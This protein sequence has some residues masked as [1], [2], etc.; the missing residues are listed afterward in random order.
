[1]CH[2]GHFLLARWLMPRLLASGAPRVVLVSSVAHESPAKLDFDQLPMSRANFKGM[3]AYGQ[4][5]LC[6]VLMAKELQARYGARGLTACAL[7]PG[8]LVTTDIGRHSTVAGV[9]VRLVS[10]FT[11]SPL[12]GAATSVYAAVHEPAADLAGQYLQDCR[13]ARCSAE[14]NDPTVARRLWTVSEQWIASA[15]A[16]DWP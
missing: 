5:K 1:V 13:I 6:N 8:T 9:L 4:A 14:A 15:A 2:I 16:P 11:K 3:A 7:H 10:P 12:Q